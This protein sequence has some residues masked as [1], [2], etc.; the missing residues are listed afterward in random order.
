[1][2]RS[3]AGA[4]KNTYFRGKLTGRRRT[5]GTITF[6]PNHTTAMEVGLDRSTNPKSRGCGTNV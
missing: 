5:G 4:Q 1:M 6:T 2:M 3:P